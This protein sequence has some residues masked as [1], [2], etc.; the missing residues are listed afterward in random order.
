MKKIIIA[1]FMIIFPLLSFAQITEGFEGA[2]FPPATPGNWAVLDNGVGTA[3][4]W[5]ETT[6]PTRCILD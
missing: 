3:V 5:T 1:F 2:T 4:S 6:D